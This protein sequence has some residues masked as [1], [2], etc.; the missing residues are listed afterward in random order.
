M[1]KILSTLLLVLALV[2][3]TSVATDRSAFAASP[4]QTV[5][6]QVL[7]PN[8]TAWP[9]AT[10]SGT[11]QNIYFGPGVGP[12][13]VQVELSQ[14]SGISAGAIT[15]QIT[16]DGTNWTTIPAA[17]VLDPTAALA[18]ISL[19]YTLVASTNKQFLLLTRGAQGLRIEVSTTTAGGSVT[20]YWTL[21]G[22]SGVLELNPASLTLGQGSTTSGQSGSMVMGATTTSPPSETTGQTNAL[23]LD[24]NGGLRTSPACTKVINITQTATTDVKTMTG[25]ASIC[26]IVL[27]SASAQSIGIDEGTGTTCE[28]SGTALIGVSSTASATPTVAVAANGGFSVGNGIPFMRTQASGDHLCV[29]QS[30]SGNVSGVITYQDGLN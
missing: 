24:L 1:S 8:P 29:L 13:A 23:S 7:N 4:T 27:V 21:L 16:N 5:P 25:F 28:T 26:S 19:P 22:A 2:A 14:G 11:V 30:G 10:T 18:Q 17:Q 3:V 12:A 20:P 6:G 9:A 15:F